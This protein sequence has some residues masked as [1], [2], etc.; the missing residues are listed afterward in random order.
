M[1]NE[2]FIN[3]FV[4][5]KNE[6]ITWADKIPLILLVNASCG[7][8]NLIE[9]MTLLQPIFLLLSFLS[10]SRERKNYIEKQKQNHKPFT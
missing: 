6:N 9:N 2:I 8:Y 10:F 5:S 3:Y 7:V 4:L 1:T